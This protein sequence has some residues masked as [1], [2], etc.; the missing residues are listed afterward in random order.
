MRDSILIQ[1]YLSPSK[2][3]LQRVHQ[4]LLINEGWIITPKVLDKISEPSS[5]YFINKFQRQNHTN[6]GEY[7]IRKRIHS[8]TR[9]S[10]TGVKKIRDMCVRYHRTFRWNNVLQ[11]Q[12]PNQRL[13]DTYMLLSRTGDQRDDLPV[14]CPQF[15]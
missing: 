4:K 7:E 13:K 3:T 8:Q 2:P 6:L 15:S 5:L 11:P 14:H 1:N 12:M 9:Q 10:S